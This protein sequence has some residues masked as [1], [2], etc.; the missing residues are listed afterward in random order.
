MISAPHTTRA[1]DSSFNPEPRKRAQL[2][3]AIRRLESKEDTVVNRSAPAHRRVALAEAYFRLAILRG[4]ELPEAL[5]YLQQAIEHDPYHPK[6]FFHLGRLLHRGG[7]FL[8]AAQAYRRALRL[9]PT[10]HRTYAH[11]ALALLE[12]EDTG[13]TLGRTLLEALARGDEAKLLEQL[14]KV[15]ELLEARRSDSEEKPDEEKKPAGQPATEKVKTQASGNSKTSDGNAATSGPRWSGVWRVALVDLLTGKSAGRKKKEIDTQLA[16][17]AKRVQGEQGIAE[18]ATACLFLMLGGELSAENLNTIAKLLDGQVFKEHEAHPA[19]RL[20]RRTLLLARTNEAAAF[21]KSANDALNENELPF[22][23]VCYLHYAKYGPEQV[24]SIGQGLELLQQYSET[25]R[26]SD[27]FIELRLAILDGYARRAWVD[28]KFEHAKLLWRE[29]VPLDPNRIEAA[30]NLALLAARTKARDDYEAAW[31][32]AFELRYLHAAAAQNVRVL[33]EDRRTMHLSFAQQSE[34]LYAN[35][36][37]DTKDTDEKQRK[38]KRL[39]AWLADRVAMGTWLREWD[40]YYLNSRLRFR[41]PVHLLGVPRDTVADMV[42]DARDALL[43]QIDT[44]LRPQTWAGIKTFCE[45]ADELVKRSA[46]SASDIIERTRDL[47]Y[48]EE[49]AEADELAKETI[50]RGFLLLSLLAALA[51]KEDGADLSLGIQIA[52]H[53]FAM[54]W[55]ILQP[56]CAARGLIDRDDDLLEIFAGNFRRLILADTSEPADQRDAERRLALLDQ[57]LEVLP[58]DVAFHS[59][60]CRY[61]VA[62]R[63]T[64]EAYA[65]GIAALPLVD[66]IEDEEQADILRHNLTFHIDNAALTELRAQVRDPQTREEAERYVAAGQKLLEKFPRAAGFRRNLADI[67]IQLGSAAQIREAVQ[68][69]KDGLELALTD[70]QRQELSDMLGKADKQAQSAA[71]L[72]EIKKLLDDAT[73]TVNEV[74]QEIKESQTVETRQ[75]ARDVVRH[76]VTNAEQARSLAARAGLADAQSQAEKRVEQF[77]KLEAQL[78]SLG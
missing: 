5:S 32:R 75:K 78:S 62:A 3:E 41:A 67:L 65:A 37:K 22:E 66:K 2:F 29:T 19:V 43:R 36:G 72:N 13:K 8:G 7:D 14:A 54:P 53:L 69:L 1:D 12:L 60:R 15:N 38:Q 34:Q 49:K 20:A 27:S 58:Y 71:V 23:L 24:P 52:R 74:I 47:Y 59:R 21:V 6:L 26:R 46:E 33:I 18:Y 68:I 9:A 73:Q 55:R 50:E 30:H 40:L 51:N 56:I 35:Y 44:L 11:L 31:N 10:S 48:E 25:A 64:E 76:A 63:R 4:T 17:G 16:I 70:E 61:L 28:E 45:L 39:E 42:T 57:C 77:R